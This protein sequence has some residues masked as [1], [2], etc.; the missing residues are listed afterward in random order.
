MLNHLQKATEEFVRRVCKKKGLPE[1]TIQS[2]GGK[3]FTFG[4]YALGVSNPGMG[5][6]DGTIAVDLADD[7]A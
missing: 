3:L 4:S 2:A 1:S 7:Y 5:S 6:Y